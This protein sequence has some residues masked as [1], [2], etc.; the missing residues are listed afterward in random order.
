MAD[1]RQKRLERYEAW[2]AECE[3]L[4]RVAA[5]RSKQKQYEHLA[6][7]YHYLAASF[8][9]ALAMHSAALARLT[10]H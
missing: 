3:I 1:V 6:A 4:A 5:D 2:A 9:E 7:H 10:L 8:R